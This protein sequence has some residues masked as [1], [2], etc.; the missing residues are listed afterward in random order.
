MR[1]ALDL[2]LEHGRGVVHVRRGASNAAAVF[3]TQA[4]LPHVRQRLSGARSA[5]V[6]LQLAPRLVPGM[7]RHGRRPRAFRRRA[8]RRGI[9]LATRRRRGGRGG[10]L[11]GLQRRAA[12][13][14]RAPR[15]VPGP[16][17]RRA[18]PAAGE[19]FRRGPGQ[20]QARGPRTRDRTRHRRR[21]RLA[22]ALSVRRGLGLPGARPLRAHA[23]RRRGPAHPAGGATRIEPARRVLRARRARPSACIRATTLR[24]STPSIDCGARATR[25]SWSSTTRR[26][27]AARTTSSI[28]VPVQEC[29]AASSWRE[30]TAAELARLGN[31]ATGRCLAS[32][33]QHSRSRRRPVV[34]DTPSIRRARRHAA[35]S[36]QGRR[37]HPA[38]AL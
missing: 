3:S 25:W 16:I 29:A 24:C 4:R 1:Q 7:L 26:R 30:G 20:V 11:P 14:R 21:A 8:E 34:R 6:L 5:P 36:A 27:S 10:G 9:R 31:S 35:Q 23:L 32:P 28:W 2:A 38:G 12:Q 15:A 33:L 17:H 22:H 19:G 37:A 13:S 18:H